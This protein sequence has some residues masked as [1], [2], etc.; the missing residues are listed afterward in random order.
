[1]VGGLSKPILGGSGAIKPSAL[2]HIPVVF[3]SF[4]LLCAISL[5]ASSFLSLG[6]LFEHN[7][8]E[9]WNIYNTQRLMGHEVVYDSNYWR[10][11][12]YPIGSFL[13]VGGINFLVHDLLICGRIVALLSLAAI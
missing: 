7:Y 13:I 6:F 10:I 9:G 2:N 8:N 12:N 3:A 11:N 1:M 4:V 5:S